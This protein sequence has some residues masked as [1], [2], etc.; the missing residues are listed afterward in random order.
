VEQTSGMSFPRWSAVS[1]VL[2]AAATALSGCSGGGAS[3]SKLPR[4]SHGAPSAPEGHATV[5]FTPDHRVTDAVLRRAADRVGRRARALGI[6]DAKVVTADGKVTVTAPGGQDLGERIA[7][8]GQPAVLE[9]RPVLATAAPQAASGAATGAVPDALRRAFDSQSCA[10]SAASA[11]SPAAEAVLCDG[12][13]DGKRAKA[14]YALGPA[15]L[16]G[17]AVR[18]ADAH[19]DTQSASGWLVD[20]DFTSKGAHEF[21]DITQDL[22]TRQA[23]NNQFAIVLDGSVLSAPAVMQTITGGKAQISGNLDKKGAGDLA[24]MIDSGSLPVALVVRESTTG[25]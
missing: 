21:A 7:G 10:A 20:L 13:Q 1:V 18:S 24:A 12:G 22:S 2:L 16:G 14:K 9:F 17:D 15:R 11:P 23:P 3:S 5:V 4:A 8:L 19:L 25:S 6:D